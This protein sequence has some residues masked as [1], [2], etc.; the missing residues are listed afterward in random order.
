[1]LKTLSLLIAISISPAS[2]AVQDLD[3]EIHRYVEM[4]NLGTPSPTPN[5]DKL[6]FEF[7]KKLFSDNTLSLTNNI[8][9]HTCHSTD[10][11]SSDGLPFSIGTGGIGEGSE[12]IQ[13]NAHITPRSSP[14]L[15]NKGHASVK[16]MFWDGRVRLDSRTN[17]YVTPEPGLNGSNPKLDYIANKIENVMAMQALFPMV[18]PVEMM[19]EKNSTLSNEAA[20]KLIAE[21]VK[22]DPKY[23]RYVSKIAD[24]NIADIANALSYFQTIRFE[25]TNTPYD[26][27]LAGDKSALTPIEKEGAMIF[28][29]SGRCVRCHNGPLLS[30]NA[31]QSVATPQIGAGIDKNKDDL[32]LFHAI[33]DPRAKYR[34]KTQPL[35]N[36]ALTAPYMHNGVFKD[37]TEVMVHYNNPRISNDNYSTNEIQR[38]FFKNYHELFHH[39]T[40]GARNEARKNSIERML[41]SPLNLS[42]SDLA[43]LVCF[44]KKSLTEKKFHSGLD[45][46]ECESN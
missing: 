24:F 11:G 6:K 34:F 22:S 21:R 33:P 8:S 2:M 39:D 5:S 32:G 31:F 4:F 44:V 36:V 28:L 9:C 37:L 17:T 16:T 38:M 43:K 10:F 14:H 27:Y 19:G 25:V 3:N 20:W 26:E 23:N 40:D 15:F 7:G 18:N 41:R 42:E 1:M 46:S 45:L 13:G 30:N 12:R 29:D 35:R